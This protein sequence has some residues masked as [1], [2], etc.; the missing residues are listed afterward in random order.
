MPMIGDPSRFALEH[1]LDADPHGVW[2]FGRVCFWVAGD[3]V[4]DFELGTSLRDVLFLLEEGRRD[5]GRRENQRFA[6]LPA[7]ELVEELERGLAAGEACDAAINEQWARHCITPIVDVFDAWRVYLV[8]V[9]LKARVLVRRAGKPLDVRET[10][11][12]RGEVDQVLGQA[13][14]AIGALYEMERE[15]ADASD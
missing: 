15:K 3:R 4:G 12:R 10:I 5:A 14:V 6:S 1:E 9:D 13:C 2:L 11:L 8:E 7:A